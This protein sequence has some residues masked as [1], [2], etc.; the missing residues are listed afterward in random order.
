LKAEGHVVRVEWRSFKD[1][2]VG[3]T[4]TK[5][6]VPSKTNVKRKQLR[7]ERQTWEETK[8]A[9]QKEKQDKESAS[10]KIRQ[11]F[12]KQRKTAELQQRY[13]NHPK[14]FKESNKM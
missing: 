10:L 4:P 1:R 11:D 3:K 12:E 14:Y 2:G 6:Q 9:G 13:N 5:H 8:T 7:A